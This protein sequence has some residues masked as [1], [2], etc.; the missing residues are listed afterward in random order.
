METNTL[1]YTVVKSFREKGITYK[2]TEEEYNNMLKNVEYQ[3]YNEGSEKRKS[4][5]L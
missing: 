4:V 2:V 5:Y 3:R 1:K